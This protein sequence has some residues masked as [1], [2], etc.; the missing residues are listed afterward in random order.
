MA[1]GGKR[2]G[3]GRKPSS[4]T[5]KRREAVERAAE[6]GIL[7]LDVMLEAMREAH[8]EG[9]MKDAVAAA[10]VAAPYVHPRLAAVAHE[11]SDGGPLQVLI[12]KFSDGA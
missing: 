12:Q 9:R 5:M 7:P 2:P 1:A 10:V 3:A 4:L 8:S 6:A 11:G